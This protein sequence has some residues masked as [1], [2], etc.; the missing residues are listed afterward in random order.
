[1]KPSSALHEIRRVGVRSLDA[2][3]LPYGGSAIAPLHT[4]DNMKRL[5]IP[6]AAVIA[7]L[8]TPHIHNELTPVV[9]IRTVDFTSVA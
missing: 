1:M 3:I 7:A 5:T 6:F 4:D 2:V 8:R 9:N